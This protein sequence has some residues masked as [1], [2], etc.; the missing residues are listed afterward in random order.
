MLEILDKTFNI[1]ELFLM[2]NDKYTLPELA[3]LSGYNVAT[4]NRIVTKLVQRGYLNKIK[5]RK[6]YR[7]G[8]KILEF[9]PLSFNKAELRR[10]VEP[11][12]VELSKHID[13]TIVFISWDKIEF[14]MI[15]V[16]PSVQPLKV[17][18]NDRPS[19]EDELYHTASGKAILASMTES[20]FKAYCRNVPMKAYTPNTIMDINELKNQLSLIRQEGI[21]YNFEEDQ[22]GVNT[23][24]SVVKN[25]EGNV[26][27]T[28]AVL[29][30]SAR[31][32]RARM[33]Q[34]APEIRGVAGEIS[35][36]LGYQGE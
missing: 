36:T 14:S 25:G 29:G 16:I 13:E 33:R 31:L 28:V 12:L 3:R 2:N 21:A 35:R 23:V 8:S 6:G 10:V 34:F 9:R 22:I 5:S 4:I 19:L 20:E 24:A 30:P 32:A 11:F 1:L 26:I 15:T 18:P 17:I 27:G 7:L